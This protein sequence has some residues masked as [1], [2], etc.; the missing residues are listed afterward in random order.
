MCATTLDETERVI[1]KYIITINCY[2]KTVKCDTR[3]MY[4][5]TGNIKK[6]IDPA[7]STGGW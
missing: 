3:Q 2:Y 1:E 7:K 5:S 4:V 6:N